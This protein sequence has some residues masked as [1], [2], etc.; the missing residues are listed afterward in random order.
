MAICDV[1]QGSAA[2]VRAG[3]HEAVVVD[4]GPDPHRLSRCLDDLDVARCRWSSSATS[5][6]IMSTA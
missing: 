6:P 5:T 3:P 2:L 4:T 1:G